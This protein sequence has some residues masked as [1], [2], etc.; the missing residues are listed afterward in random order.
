[1]KFEKIKTLKILEFTYFYSLML[2]VRLKD[3]LHI[4]TPDWFSRHCKKKDKRAFRR[5]SFSRISTK[6][7]P[8]GMESLAHRLQTSR[9]HT[10]LHSTVQTAVQRGGAG[11]DQHPPLRPELQ[12]Q[13]AVAGVGGGPQL[14]RHTVQL[15]ALQCLHYRTLASAC[16]S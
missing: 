4:D 7:V 9:P 11:T 10:H 2:M 12:R 3:I 5:Q 13:L 6:N 8:G 14:H 15:V 16:C 1:M